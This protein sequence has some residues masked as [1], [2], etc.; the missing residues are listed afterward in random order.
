[1][2]EFFLGTHDPTLVHVSN[3]VHDG[4]T[5]VSREVSVVVNVPTELYRYDDVDE[6]R[7]EQPGT[8][9]CDWTRKDG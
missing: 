1:M 7:L 4:W 5:C 3:L 8:L 6:Y 2:N 9:P